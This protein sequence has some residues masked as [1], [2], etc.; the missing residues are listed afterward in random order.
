[1]TGALIEVEVIE[2]GYKEETLGA[3]WLA[4][5]SHVDV[6]TSSSLKHTDTW[7]LFCCYY[8]W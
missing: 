8:I 4:V 1:M 2:F 7:L 6:L 5:S 3:I